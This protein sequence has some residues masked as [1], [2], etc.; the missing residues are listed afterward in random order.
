MSD[1]IGQARRY[2]QRTIT[3]WRATNLYRFAT[4]ATVLV[5]QVCCMVVRWLG[6]TRFKVMPSIHTGQ[7]QS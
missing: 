5:I 4:E 2:L 7:R 1:I 3:A 6:I